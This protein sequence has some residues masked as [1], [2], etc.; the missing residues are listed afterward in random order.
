LPEPIV[1]PI[2][3]PIG[4]PIPIK[5]VFLKQAAI[6]SPIGMPNPTPPRLDQRFL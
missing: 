6:T 2:A 1:M 3:I 5:A 4:N